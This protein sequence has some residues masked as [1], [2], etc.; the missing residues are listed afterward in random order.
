LRTVD[1][2]LLNMC[3]YRPTPGKRLI[4]TMNVLLKV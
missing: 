3:T 1:I 2:T 4:T